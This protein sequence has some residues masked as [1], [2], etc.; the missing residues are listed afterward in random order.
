[1]TRSLSSKVL[2]TSNKKTTPELSLFFI[3]PLPADELLALGFQALH[4]FARPSLVEVD[5]S[6]LDWPNVAA[7]DDH[8]IEPNRLAFFPIL[9]RGIAFIVTIVFEPETIHFK[10]HVVAPADAGEFTN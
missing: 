3:K 5:Y 6:P 1:M 4:L 10:I 9:L 2:S 7:G 8:I